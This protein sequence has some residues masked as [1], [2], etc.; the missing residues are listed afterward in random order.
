VDNYKEAVLNYKKLVAL[1]PENQMYRQ[2][3]AACLFLVDKMEEGINW[4]KS[5][6][7][8]DPD[9]Q[10]VI[11]DLINVYLHLGNK[12]KALEYIDK[13]NLIGTKTADINFKLGEIYQ[14]MEMTR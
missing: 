1:K 12:E 3:L 2:N 13:V 7:E 4:L 10:G 9:N 5:C 6:L 14:T 8:D 11:F